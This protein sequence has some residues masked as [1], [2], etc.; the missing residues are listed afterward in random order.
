MIHN[1]PRNGFTLIE[2]LITV[3]ILVTVSTVGFFTFTSYKGSQNVRLTMSELVAVIRDVQKRSITEQDGKRWGLRFINSTGTIHSYEVF[4]G[5]SYASGTVNSLY[6]LKRGVAFGNPGDGLNMDV[7]FSAISGKLG[8]TRIISLISQ[9][10]DNLV[11]DVTMLPQGKI[12]TRLETGVVGYWHFD[13]ATSTESYDSSGFGSTGTLTDGP[14]WQTSSNCRA[15]ECLS[16]DGVNDYVDVSDGDSLGLTDAF[17]LEAW[18][19]TPSFSTI[20]ALITKDIGGGLS[21]Y[22]LSI[23]SV[24][25]IRIEIATSDCS[26]W[27]TND[28]ANT[29]LQLNTWQHISVTYDGNTVKHYLNGILDDSFVYTD[30]LCVSG[31]SLYIGWEGGSQYANGSI[32]EVRIYN[33]ALSAEEIQNHYDDLK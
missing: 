32:D 9:R 2:I 20:S 26:G 31:N 3:A 6:P 28:I 17:T 24:G 30:S 23:H 13:E 14:T 4:S 16:F 19:K 8:G 18:F 5:V 7:I 29:V 15:G 33:H 25:K 10:R 22:R 1:S 12:T 11:G 21:S 27:G